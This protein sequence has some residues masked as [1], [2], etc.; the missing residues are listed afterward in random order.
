MRTVFVV[1]FDTTRTIPVPNRL[2]NPIQITRSCTNESPIQFIELCPNQ[3]SS[4][5]SQTSDP[6][7][8]VSEKLISADVDGHAPQ[9]QTSLHTSPLQLETT[10]VSQKLFVA[11]IDNDGLLDQTSIRAGPLQ[12]I[13][14]NGSTADDDIS[15]IVDSTDL[16][17]AAYREAV[18]SF[19]KDI[20]V[21]ILKGSSAA[22]LLEKLED[23]DKQ[24]TQESVFLRGVAYLRS[25]QIPLERF[26][27]AL[28][29][30]APLGSVDPTAST[31]LGVVRSVTA[32]S[33]IHRFSTS[34]ECDDGTGT[35]CTK[36]RLL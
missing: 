1:N 10:D 6:A 8:D 9:D 2:G 25:I 13:R 35:D 24:A 26:K 20:D 12:P 16:W 29:L 17:S 32:V 7:S 33:F 28:D 18:E 21:A 14:S 23:V 11:D 4:V 31:V 22:Q 27:L 30:A 36:H 15:T 19:G 5:D 34:R 3:L